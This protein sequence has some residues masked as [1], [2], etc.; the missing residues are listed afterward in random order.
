M[1]WLV[2]KAYNIWLQGTILDKNI[3]PNVTGFLLLIKEKCA[4]VTWNKKSFFLFDS[5]GRD[6]QGKTSPDGTATLIKFNSKKALESFIFVN[7]TIPSDVNVQFELQ[8]LSISDEN[9]SK[10][11]TI[12]QIYSKNNSKA[13]PEI[14][15]KNRKR[16]AT[17]EIREK[18]RKRK[19]TPEIREKD[20]KRK[21][22]PEI[23]EK[24]RNRKATPEIR[25]KDRKR[26][27]LAEHKGKRCKHKA[28]TTDSRI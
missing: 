7:Y 17:P 16:K 2:T 15:E 12:Y 18:D 10:A 6:I 1:I 14:R 28:L 3:D 27:A 24:D 26:K 4:S 9:K 13:T 23:K 25:E 5:H 19:A 21:A 20:R 11:L 22:T 8:Y